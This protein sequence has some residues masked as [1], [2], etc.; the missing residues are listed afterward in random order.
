MS[1]SGN[2]IANGLGRRAPRQGGKAAGR[3]LALLAAALLW[4]PTLAAAGDARAAAARVTAA[5]G[6]TLASGGAVGQAGEVAEGDALATG[7]AGG[8]A[9]LVD[10]DAVVEL[11]ADTE[12]TLEP[13]RGGA[14]VVRLGRGEVRL[15]VEPRGAGERVEIHTPAAIATI[16]GSVIHVAVDAQGVTTVRSSES[17]VSVTSSSPG[18]KGATQVGPGQQIVVRPGEAPP[19]TARAWDASQAR[20]GGCLID[21]HA[22]ARENGRDARELEAISQLLAGDL[23]DALPGVGLGPAT[24][25]TPVLAL[26]PSDVR[27]EQLYDATQIESPPADALPPCGFPG[28]FCG[29]R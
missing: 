2:G 27:Y 22:L 18:V 25:V 14:R 9:L 1:G 11:C 20:A 19:A 10:G 16:L 28:E 5:T 4:L 8:C 6:A 21:F 7:D 3:P 15:V 24:S 23:V 13:R 26:P 12:L 17:E 29:G